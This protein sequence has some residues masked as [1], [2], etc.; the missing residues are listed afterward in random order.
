MQNEAIVRKPSLSPSKITTYLACP[1]KY[2]WTY[3][4]PRGKMFL[5]SKAYYS[6]GASLHL[7]LQ[8]FHDSEDAGVTTAVEAAA[9][10]EESWISAGYSSPEEAA[11]ALAEGRELITQYVESYKAKPTI[12]KTLFVEK[13]L[14]ADLGAFVL[15]GRIDRIDERDD[16]TLEIVDYKSGREATTIEELRDD[17]AMNCYQLLVRSKMPGRRVLSTIVA[18]RTN[19]EMSYEPS[20]E[21][22]ESFKRDLEALGIEI[23]EKNYDELRPIAKPICLDCDFVPLC[24]RDEEFSEALNGLSRAE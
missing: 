18:L 16:G 4:D 12:G 11:E 1:V 15:I 19:H 17:I 23:I 2:R 20:D 5:R 7:V 8:R 24:S 9:K 14:R 13:Q 21:E 22:L 3:V 6:F 10:L